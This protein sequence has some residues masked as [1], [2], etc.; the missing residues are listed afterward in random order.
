MLEWNG[1]Q[2][3]ATFYMLY[4]MPHYSGTWTLKVNTVLHRLPGLQVSPCNK[5]S[6]GAGPSSTRSSLCSSS[7]PSPASRGGAGLP[8]FERNVRGSRFS[9]KKVWGFCEA[10]WGSD[11]YGRFRADHYKNCMAVSKH[12]DPVLG[13][14]CEGSFHSRS[15]FGALILGSAQKR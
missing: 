3:Y 11:I 8:R 14:L 1:P 13:Y 6:S 2:K 9:T 7:S 5:R 10:L 15:I 12:G 4:G